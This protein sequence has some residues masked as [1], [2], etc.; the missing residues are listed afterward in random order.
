M[1]RD[2][3]ANPESES[4]NIVELS[5][6]D[7]Q[8]LRDLKLRSIEEEPV[9]FEDPDEGRE[10]YQN[11]SEEEWRAILEGKMSG[12]KE[13]E[14][15]MVFADS[16][17]GYIGMVSSIVPAEQDP[18]TRTA[19]MQH[20]YVSKDK[21]GSGAGKKLIQALIEKLR[22]RGDLKKLQLEVVESQTPAIELYKSNGF[23]EVGRKKE[24]I[25][26]DGQIYDEI[27]MELDLN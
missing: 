14:T 20:M 10:K 4:V 3:I 7:W 12:G 18:E 1:G 24:A 16:P 21:R 27:E 8:I 9:A 2:R 11:R 22:N 23:V 25:N 17:E 15:M 26:R 19:T 6:D 5:P 13:G